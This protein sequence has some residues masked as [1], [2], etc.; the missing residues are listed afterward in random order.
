MDTISTEMKEK[1]DLYIR[2]GRN[3]YINSGPQ[4]DNQPFID[5]LVTQANIP[6]TDDQRSERLNRHFTSQYQKTQHESYMDALRLYDEKTAPL[7]VETIKSDLFTTHDVIDLMET[8]QNKNHSEKQ[9]TVIESKYRIDLSRSEGALED[10][11]YNANQLHYAR[12]NVGSDGHNAPH[13]SI[14]TDISKAFDIVIDIDTYETSDTII[15]YV[16]EINTHTHLKDMTQNIQD[17][18]F[19]NDVYLTQP[20]I[21]T[22]GQS[23]G[24]NLAPQKPKN[25]QY[26]GLIP[27]IAQQL[28][29]KDGTKQ[30][31]LHPSRGYLDKTG[32]YVGFDVRAAGLYTDDDVKTL[33]SIGINTDTFIK[34]TFPQEE[35]KHLQNLM[36][37]QS[38]NYEPRLFEDNAIDLPDD[39]T[40]ERAVR[41]TLIDTRA[42]S[43]YM[44]PKGFSLGRDMREAGFFTKEGVEKLIED[45]GGN[46]YMHR[47]VAQPFTQTQLTQLPFEP[48]YA[49]NLP[50]NERKDHQLYHTARPI[51]ADIAKQIDAKN[52][53][54]F[55][56]LDPSQGYLTKDPSH[57]SFDL[58]DAAIYTHANV[59][60]LNLDLNTVVKQLF[61]DKQIENIPFKT[62]PYVDVSINTTIRATKPMPSE[63]D[64]DHTNNNTAEFDITNFGDG[65]DDLDTEQTQNV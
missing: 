14:E 56:L 32:Q 42:A 39:L 4:S 54:R 5:A 57:K 43:P 23:I 2:L 29:P 28:N 59:N 36:G 26:V 11:L 65:L 8:Y 48:Q 52:A 30:S 46:K 27:E 41:Y 1:L 19:E 55:M 22:L 58:T 50:E 53:E 37:Y 15:H 61:T 47:Y 62:D 34:Q 60:Q 24:Y 12:N 44:N 6:M 35:L 51:S 3:L 20:R 38:V 17:L 49:E 13:Q 10:L 16:K 45:H 40:D 25:K 9:V 7:S 64:F 21:E 63:L 31:L 33:N 18:H